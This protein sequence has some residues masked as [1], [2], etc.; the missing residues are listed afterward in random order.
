MSVKKLCFS[1]LVLM[2]VA[3]TTPFASHAGGGF[4]LHSPAAETTYTGQ[5]VLISYELPHPMVMPNSVELEFSNGEESTVW[6]M[7]SNMLA[8]S[9]EYTLGG[10]P[11]DLMAVVGANGPVGYG[12]YDVILRFTFMGGDGMENNGTVF[13]IWNEFVTFEAPAVPGCTDYTACNY[14][15]AATTDDGSCTYAE[16]GFACEGGCIGWE[17]PQHMLEA[18]GWHM[19]F[20]DCE[21]LEP[22]TNGNAVLVF[23]A[24]GTVSLF[25]D[26]E[27]VEYN[28]TYTNN[29][30][31]VSFNGATMLSLDDHFVGLTDGQGCFE[32]IPLPVGCTDPAACNYDDGAIF[33]PN[34]CN[35]PESASVDCDGNCLGD[36]DNDGVCDGDEIAGCTDA[37]ACNFNPTATDAANG[38]CTYADPGYDCNGNCLGQPINQE[39]LTAGA[40]ALA[41]VDCESG[42]VIELD[43]FI[44]TFDTDGWINSNLNGQIQDGSSPYTLDGCVVSFPG[45]YM[46]FVNDQY[47]GFGGEG[48]CY[49]FYPIAAG[50]TKPLACNYDP[51]AGWDDGTCIFPESIYHD[52]DGNCKNDANAN[53][54]CDEIE[55]EGCADETACNYDPEVNI[56]LVE[57][58]TYP[59]PYYDCDG[60]CLNDADNNGVCDELETEGCTDPLAFNYDANASVSNNE[61]CI[62]EC[63]M[64]TVAFFPEPCNARGFRVRVLVGEIGNGAPYIVTNSVNGSELVIDRQGTY[65]TTI[66]DSDFSV[67]FRFQSSFM[68]RCLIVSDVLGCESLAEVDADPYSVRVWPNPATERAMVTAELEG[69]IEVSIYDNAGR[70]VHSSIGRVNGNGLEINVSN[71]PIGTYVV[72]LRDRTTIATRKLIVQR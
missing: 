54:I 58:C 7:D 49:V 48:G 65:Y 27:Q 17:I 38:S 42:E 33:N 26:E 19:T 36:A 55:R 43:E 41:S 5:S 21:T 18:F 12:T 4:T 11:R 35:Y 8:V 20:V 62:Y 9:F 39:V 66:F 67:Q 63:D 37:A 29:G 22:L 53:G 51:A 15:A 28:S 60:N 68:G 52:C 72:H 59:A 31:A 1:A 70:L 10:D 61:L 69:L 14:N 40:W 16:P 44:Y 50:C 34:L 13:S 24:D 56:E 23:N 6:M 30:C 32:F 45:G 46:Q 25:V 64:P 3:L 47:I 57:S 71:L 2:M